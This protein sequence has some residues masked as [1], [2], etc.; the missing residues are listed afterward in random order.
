MIAE[1]FTDPFRYIPHPLVTKAARIVMHKVSRLEECL[2]KGF[3]EGKMMGVLVVNV[4]ADVSDF[5]DWLDEKKRI[6][7]LC[8]FSGSVAGHGFIEGFVP[9]IFDLCAPEGYY[10]LREAEI[11]TLNKRI[12]DVEES[13]ALAELRAE[14]DEA[15]G[16]RDDEIGQMKAR[17]AISK[18]ER[19][20]IRCEL[21]DPSRLAELVRESQFEKAELHRLKLSL[22]ERIS[23]IQG[24]LNAMLSEIRELKQHRAALSDELQKWIFEQYIVHD[25]LGGTSTIWDIFTRQGLIP[26]GGTGD[27]AA[28]KLLNHAFIN[29]LEPVAMGEFWY[30][31]SSDTAVRVHG[32]FY[33]SCTSKCG[34]LLDFMMTGL[35]RKCGLEKLNPSHDK[36]WAP[37]VHEATGGLGFSRPPFRNS[38][39]E[40][41]IEVQDNDGAEPVVIYEDD[42]IAVVVKPAGMPSVPGLD[43]RVSVLEW[44]NSD[45]RR[46][47]FD[48]P[49]T[50]EAVHRLDMDTS[51]IMVFAKNAEA[52]VNLKRQFEMH[53][54]RKTYMAR[55]APEACIMDSGFKL[56]EA[57]L[58]LND[59]EKGRIE[60]P[61]SPDYDERPRQKADTAQGKAA[62]TEYEVVSVNSDGTTDVLFHPITGRTHQLR[63]HSA[64]P[65]GLGRPILGDLLYGGYSIY[66]GQSAEQ[67]AEQETEKET[68]KAHD[69]DSSY[70]THAYK[71]RRLHLHALSITFRHPSSGEEVCFSSKHHC[72]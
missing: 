49:V 5:T 25:A 30:G 21:S 68:E 65:L 28:P 27:C 37:P 23:E 48:Q 12:H 18:R 16:A 20:E 61:L 53:T 60:I 38:L 13:P 71:A 64:H 40:Q 50:Y 43:G 6:G 29:G 15:K 67:E 11:S 51:G 45:E 47:V 39:K 46:S 14:L 69:I 42:R 70:I 17:M 54:V 1:G 66:S 34:P 41:H 24:R 32:H 55:L 8:A 2:K 35:F 4:P 63:V 52:A 36:S 9:P 7:F 10:R 22:S 3:E 58:P 72:Y 31:T 44:L 62:L 59:G 19:E 33:P 57:V 56:H 26:P